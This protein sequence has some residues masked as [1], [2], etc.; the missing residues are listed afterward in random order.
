[1]A[2][3]IHALAQTDANPSQLTYLLYQT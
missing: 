2:Q 3:N 1:M